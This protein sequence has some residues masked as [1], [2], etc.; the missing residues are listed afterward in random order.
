VGVLRAGYKRVLDRQVNNAINSGRFF[1]MEDKK[2]KILMVSGICVCLVIAVAVTFL[3]RSRATGLSSI[4]AGELMWVMCSNPDCQ[5]E[6][7]VGRKDFYTFMKENVTP[8]EMK[9][10]MICEECDEESVY[11]ALKCENCDVIFFY[12]VADGFMDKCTECGFSKT[13]ESRGPR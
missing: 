13:E 1:A 12:G 4:K 2:K 7:R 9:P 8:S 6:Y 3:T 11:R 5:A 10:P